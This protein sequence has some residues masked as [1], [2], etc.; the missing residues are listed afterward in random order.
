MNTV[1]QLL[2]FANILCYNI[3]RRYKTAKIPDPRREP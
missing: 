3:N 2:E 1:T